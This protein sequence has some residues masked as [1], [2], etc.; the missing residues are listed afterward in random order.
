MYPPTPYI[1]GRKNQFWVL[2]IS[3]W[4]FCWDF[5][6]ISKKFKNFFQKFQSQFFRPPPHH[7]QSSSQTAGF[8]SLKIC[9][10]NPFRFSC[11]SMKI[12]Y[13]KYMYTS[14]LFGHNWLFMAASYKYMAATKKRHKTD[15]NAFY[16]FALK[17]FAGKWNS[18]PQNTK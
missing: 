13:S 6:W 16:K 2:E 9:A 11:E 14:C 10:K 7:L 15:F 18:H 17:L 8:E 1:S 12:F 3:R 5:E 4:K